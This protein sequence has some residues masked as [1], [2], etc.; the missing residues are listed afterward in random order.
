MDTCQIAWADSL[1]VGDGHIDSQ[2]K[3]LI[4]LISSISEYIPKPKDK[5]V[6]GEAVE[7]AGTHFGDEEAYMAKIGYPALA[8][9]QTEHKRLA[10]ILMGYK[11]D[12]NEGRI[13]MFS[14]KQFMFLWIR[15]HIMDTDR[16][17][18]EFLRETPESRYGPAE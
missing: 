14:F 17:I 1:S 15:D 10:I 8:A 11:K 5:D 16:K 6:M 18:G 13:N 9:H 2:H 4:G 3:K 12:F 7:Y